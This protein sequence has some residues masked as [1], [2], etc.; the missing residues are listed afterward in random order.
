MS[1]QNKD[2]MEFAE[3]MVQHFRRNA[4][5]FIDFMTNADADIF[6][7]YVGLIMDKKAKNKLEI[8]VQIGRAVRSLM[9]D[10]DDDE[11]SFA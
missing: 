3:K 9:E 6:E 8:N 10:F 7:K 4:A 1:K 5:C 2:I 11:Y